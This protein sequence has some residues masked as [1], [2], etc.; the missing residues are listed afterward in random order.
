MS[1]PKTEQ[2]TREK[3]P[4]PLDIGAAVLKL[5]QEMGLKGVDLCRR[6]KVLDPKTLTAIEKG[7]IKNPSVATLQA[8]AGGFGITV[9]ELF[10]HAELSDERHFRIGTQKGLYKME[11]ASK[12]I[13]MVS[14]TPLNEEFFCGKIILEG[15]RGFDDSFLSHKGAFF[16][17]SLVGQVEGDVEGKTVP[18]KEGASLYLRGGMRFRLQ[19]PAQRNA[20][21]LLVTVPS[22]V[23]SGHS[24]VPL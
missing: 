20:S 2:K 9:S 24:Y 7:R 16:V 5:R 10:R 14:F 17:M 13:Q 21:L 6:A 4:A 23:S 1:K 18:L 11:F 19:N 12:G 15:E 22:C 3:S 8:L